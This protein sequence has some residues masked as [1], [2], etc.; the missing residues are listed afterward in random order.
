M[1]FWKS[2][3]SLFIMRSRS[4]L[5]FTVLTPSVSHNRATHLIGRS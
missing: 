4:S 2:F 1:F 3:L 5:S